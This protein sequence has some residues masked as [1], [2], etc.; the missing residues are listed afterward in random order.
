MNIECIYTLSAKEVKATL[1]LT[2]YTKMLACAGMNPMVLGMG[3]I[4]ILAGLGGKAMQDYFRCVTEK[5][6]SKTDASEPEESKSEEAANKG[7]DELEAQFEEFK[8]SLAGFEIYKLKDGKVVQFHCRKKIVFVERWKTVLV[9]EE[10]AS[11]DVENPDVPKHIKEL[12]EKD[13]VI[14]TE[15]EE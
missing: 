13:A 7:C 15:K 6:E 14:I 12:V 1:G 8:K 3:M 9:T 10:V 2:A 4:G 11:W 5:Q